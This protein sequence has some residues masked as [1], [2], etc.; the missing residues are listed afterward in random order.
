MTMDTPLRPLVAVPAYTVV[1]SAPRQILVC[2]ARK[3][4][5]TGATL[6]RCLRVAIAAAGLTRDLEDAG[7]AC[8]G[9]CDRPSTLAFRAKGKA[10]WYFGDLPPVGPLDAL[11]AFAR[12]YPALPDGWCKGSDCPTPLRPATLA[13]TPASVVAP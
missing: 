13:R 8:L 12:L 7:S 11:I 3:P 5:G 2:K 10:L 6:M 1:Q 4:D 9:G